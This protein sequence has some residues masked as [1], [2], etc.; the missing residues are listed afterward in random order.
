MQKRVA[1][2]I[3][4]KQKATVAM[5]LSLA[6]NEHLMQNILER[7]I[8][9][10]YYKDLITKFKENTL[11]QNI[12]VQILDKDL[13]SRYRSWTDIKGDNIS[14]ARKDLVEIVRTKKVSYTISSDKFDLSIKAIVPILKDGEVIGILEIISHFNSI[15]KQMK[16]YD[17]DSVVVLDKKFNKYLKYPFTKLF[18]GEYYV[19]NFDAPLHLREHLKKHDIKKHFNSPYLI[20]GKNIVIAY[21]L[22]SLDGEVIGHYLIFKRIDDISTKDLDFFIF[23]WLALGILVIMIIA[24]I[25]NIAMFYLM[26]KQKI[27]YKNIINSAENIVLIN[28]KKNILDVNRIFFKYFD[29]Y[30][31]LVEFKDEHEC[32]CDYFVEEEGYIKTDMDGVGW[33]DYLVANNSQTNKV[34][35]NIFNKEYYFSVSASMLSDE[36]NHCSIVF[37]DITDQENYKKELEH[38]SITDTLTGIGNRRSF[39]QKIKEEIQ[40]SKRYE[41]NLSIIMFDIDHFKKVNDTHGHNVGDEVLKEYSKLISSHIRDC[42]VFCRIGG[43]EFIVLLPH[44]TLSE[45][46]IIAEKLRVEVESCKKV[47]PITM[48]FGVVEYIKGEEVE[49]IFKRVDDALYRAKGAGRNMVVVG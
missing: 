47:I 1:G 22:K 24:G 6:D 14:K 3:L 43:E 39:H 17:V 37:S 40:R 12:W 23:K 29:S 31:S 8:D 21:E 35:V 15:S 19:A 38:L 27:Y 11:Y 9:R 25:V 49:F 46:R 13:T 26:R 41:H 7:K 5:A 32:I 16:K 34:K 48:S 4:T 28:D 33:V 45:A 42:D 18:I 10:D 36:T 2:M 20:D 44:V 30:N